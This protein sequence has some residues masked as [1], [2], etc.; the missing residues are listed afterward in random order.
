[1]VII[2]TASGRCTFVLEK[3]KTIEATYSHRKAGPIPCSIL[4]DGPFQPV[5]TGDIRV[6]S[7]DQI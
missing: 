6:P 7:K 4:E 3:I 5:E 2:T 1:M